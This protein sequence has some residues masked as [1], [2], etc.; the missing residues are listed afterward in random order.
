LGGSGKRE[1]LC[2]NAEIDGKSFVSDSES[3]GKEPR[4]PI[5]TQALRLT[6]PPGEQV[7]SRTSSENFWVFLLTKSGRVDL[8]EGLWDSIWVIALTF[9]GI[10]GLQ[11]NSG[12][13]AMMLP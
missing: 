12:G 10:G 3:R 5:V 1:S 7:A 6:M 9:S 11:D 4:M 2:H 13:R 8:M